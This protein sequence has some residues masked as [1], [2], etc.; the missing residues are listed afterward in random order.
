MDVTPRPV[1]E[2]TPP[3][4][5]GD[6]RLWL[7]PLAGLLVWQ[8]WMTL[9]LFGSWDALC[10]DRPVLSGKHPLHLYHGHLG[11]RALVRHGSTS[12]YDPAFQAGY[13]KTPVFD[14]GSRPA[15][16]ALCL[17]GGDFRPDVYKIGL[18]LV[19]LLVPL[20]LVVAGRGAGLN[21]RAVLL[22]I[23]LGLFVWWGGPCQ[24]ALR[25]G[26]LDLLLGSLAV[27]VLSGLLVRFHR[28]PGGRALLGLLASGFLA[29]LFHPLLVFL[30]LPLYALYYLSVGARHRM[31]WSVLLLGGFFLAVG[32]NY[33]WLRDWVRY[34]WLLV[35]LGP[36][37]LLQHRTFASLWRAP[38][39]GDAPD[40]VLAVLMVA[41]TAG[42]AAHLNQRG[43]RPAARLF[44]LGTL[45]L[46]LLAIGGVMNETLGKLNAAAL[47]VPALLFAVA[48]AAHGLEMTWRLLAA[49]SRRRWLA[50]GLTATALG[51]VLLIPGVAGPIFQ[52]CT[53]VEPLA[54]G[55]NADQEQIVETLREHTAETARILWET[56]PGATSAA[57]WTPLLPRLTG[58][59]YVGG[60]DA[61]GG[62]EHTAD[63]LARQTLAG[64]PL[65]EWTDHDLEDYCRRYNIGWV[66][67]WTGPTLERF[68]RWDATRTVVTL[69]PGGVGTLLEVKRPH[70]FILKGQARW[71]GAE[72]GRIRLADVRPDPGDGT[73]ELSLHY[74]NGLVASP[75]RVQ[76]I[77]PEVPDGVQDLPFVRLKVDSPVAHLT[78]LWK[79]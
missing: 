72:P 1:S 53:A 74:Q 38:L 19:N 17:T 22:S 18:A 30:L 48:P 13:P 9:G 24:A 73:V 31:I 43:D 26:A 64:R 40:R 60:L 54:L 76:I 16:V 29:W 7:L 71:L 56:P 10:D 20:A 66:V 49:L 15:E 4:T 14:G 47:I 57:G 39:W 67:C 63:T 33:F 46:L 51:G 65:A 75:G 37:E 68:K 62:I 23:L 21:R 27:V 5:P 41:F 70:S 77:R 50:G 28:K 34:W 8:G 6:S 11:A 12:S 55:L 45:L 32:A 36:G 59:S 25:D 44:G 69:G 2:G 52:R 35:P 3:G 79:R 58:R 61:A 42:G 78:L